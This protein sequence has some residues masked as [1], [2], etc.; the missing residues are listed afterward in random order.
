MAAMGSFRDAAIMLF[1]KW[2]NSDDDDSTLQLIVPDSRILQVLKLLHDIPSAGNLGTDK[3]LKRIQQSFF[4]PAMSDAVRRYIK[5]CDSCTARKLS[6]EKNRAPLGTYLVGEP[7]EKVAIDILGPL[8]LSK[9]GKRYSREGRLLHK[10]D[11]ECG[12]TKPGSKNCCRGFCESLRL[13][14]WG[15]PSASQRPRKVF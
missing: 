10:V 3:T 15:A 14:L 9:S 4:W 11:R 7:I 5:S 6:R 8:P 12:Y 1:R 13:S 2:S